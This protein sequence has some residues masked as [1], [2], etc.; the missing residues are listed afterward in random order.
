MIIHE[1]SH[2]FVHTLDHK[3]SYEAGYKQLTP[4]Q[5]PNNADSIAWVA[6]GLGADV[7]DTNMQHTV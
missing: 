5:A 7:K 3:Y 1:A 6:V 2:R 4:M